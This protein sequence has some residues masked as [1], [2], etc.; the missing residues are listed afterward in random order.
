MCITTFL[1]YSSVFPL[2]LVS[3]SIGLG[4]FLG[5]VTHTKDIYKKEH[6]PRGLLTDPEGSAVTGRHGA[7][8]A[9]GSSTS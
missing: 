8:E 7:A 6:L 3:T 9:A 1:S 4:V 2:S 5:R